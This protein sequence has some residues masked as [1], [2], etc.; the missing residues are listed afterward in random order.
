MKTIAIYIIALMG[1]TSLSAQPVQ[2]EVTIPVQREVTLMQGEELLIPT[3]EMIPQIFG[4]DETG[5]YALS[6][7]HRYYIE[8]FDHNFKST[9][10]NH[11]ILH[12]GF[13]TRELEAMIYFHDKIYLFSSEERFSRKILY[14]Q[15]IDKTNLRQFNDE[16]IVMEIE[17]LK[18]WIAKFHFKLSRKEDKLL[19]YSQRDAY[20]QKIQDLYFHMYGKDLNLEWEREERIMYDR[21]SPR[22]S[23]VKVDDRGNVF[24]M[25][26]LDDQNLSSLVH[27]MKNRYFLLALTDSGR[28]VSHYPIDFPNQYIRGIQIEPG[29]NHDLSCVGF[30]SPTHFRGTIDGIFYFELNNIENKIENLRFH[31]I[32]SS[33]LNEAMNRDLMKDTENMFSYE[34]RHLILR[35]NGEFI[36]L[37]E[38]EFDQNYDNYLNIMAAGFSPGGALN[39][40]MIIPKRQSS[41]PH[42]EYNYCSYA[43]HAPWYGDRINLVF[44]DN[45]K[46]GDWPTGKKMYGFNANDKA[47]LKTVGI[48]T[49]GE[50]TSSIIY[51]KTRKRMKTPLPILFF[52][53]LDDS[54]VIPATRFRKLSFFKINF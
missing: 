40:K 1:L 28:I 41:D 43:L 23:E 52:D 9:G 45:L 46:N 7:D 2:R 37:A 26:L 44:N 16:R 6:K 21:R 36:M 27:D 14:V 49:S 34:V 13:R 8:H 50:L 35:D 42:S 31:E 47:N 24:I 15:T 39:W 51:R 4:M 54:M 32:E 29:K 18:G 3:S 12:M 5:Y 11:M 48:G 30:Y 17:N 19:V 20:M 25:S 38:N 22:E 53:P 33:F 10:E